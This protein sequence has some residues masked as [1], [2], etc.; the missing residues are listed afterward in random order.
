MRIAVGGIF[1]E[2]NTF[3]S[4][5][6]TMEKFAEKHLHF[7][8]E[9]ISIW[10]GT[11]SEMGGFLEGAKRFSHDVVPTVMAWGMPCGPLTVGTFETLSRELTSRLEAA[12]PLDGILL[13]LHGA[14]VSDNY[15][16][17]DGEL[18]RRVR[19]LASPAMPLVVTLDYHANLTEEMVRWADAIIGYDTY[20]HVD[21]F[22][23]GLEAAELLNLML[24]E[25]VRPCSYL[26]RR[27]MLPHILRQVTAIP[28]MA[29]AIALA[30]E[31][32]RRPEI[33]NVT[34]AAGF[35]YCDV[36]DG[37]LAVAATSSGNNHAA[38]EAA[39]SIAD[40]IWRRRK[41]FHVNLP[42]PDEAVREAISAPEGLSVVVDVGD[43]IGA[44]TPGDGTILLAELLRQGARDALVLLPDPEGVSRAVSAGVRE[45]VRLSVGGKTD[46]HH[47]PPVEIE[48]VVR[49]LSDGVFR[50][51]GPMH[52]GL[53]EDQGRTAVIDTGRIFVVLTERRIPMWNLQQLR[54]LGIEPTLLRIILVKGAVAH[55][56]AYGPI[57]KQ[58]IEADT[59]GLA[60]G[61]VRKLSFQRLKR[62]IYPLDPI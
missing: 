36:P 8:A 58:M 52:D 20:P 13:S 45:R 57:A 6:M 44:G 29:D 46:R 51:I 47:G 5:A 3:I 7:G 25:G 54:A 9:I 60:A 42:A 50:N 40:S 22:D 33:L 23:R 35:A 2:S 53:T 10:R 4:Q 12:G 16:D 49:T 39:E 24:R 62:P 48:G 17:G 56:A 26:A 14:M 1:H 61:N 59:P 30:H 37:G 43:N 27:P 19:T 18:L 28:P 38:R 21:Q 11:C 15:S 31:Y 55:R 34:I 32:E 41:E